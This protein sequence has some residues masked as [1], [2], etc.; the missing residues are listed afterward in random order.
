MIK[1]NLKRYWLLTA[2][3]LAGYLT[4]FIAFG[5]AAEDGIILAAYCLAV[6]MPSITAA[7]VMRRL[8]KAETSPGDMIARLRLMNSP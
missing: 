1:E 4:A 3:S 7:L 5:N 8:R 6:V 2:I